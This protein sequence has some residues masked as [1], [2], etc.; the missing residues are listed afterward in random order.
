M[1]GKPT[2][3]KIKKWE[4]A[5]KVKKLIN[6]MQSGDEYLSELAKDALENV[7]ASCQKD[8]YKDGKNEVRIKAV[9][10]ILKL[11]EEKILNQFNI[12]SHLRT[13]LNNASN[14]RLRLLIIKALGELRDSLAVKKIYRELLYSKWGVNPNLPLRI[15]AEKALK[16]IN[17]MDSNNCLSYYKR[18]CKTDE[19]ERKQGHSCRVCN[20]YISPL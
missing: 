14:I 20:T 4:K 11:K 17:S 19:E 10:T 16:K 9:K 13:N 5:K 7:L 1:M 2:P 8:L 15:E 3:N 18:A 12:A 6:N